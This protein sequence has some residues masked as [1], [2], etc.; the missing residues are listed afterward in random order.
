MRGSSTLGFRE[1]FTRATQ[2]SALAI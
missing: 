1:G 2:F